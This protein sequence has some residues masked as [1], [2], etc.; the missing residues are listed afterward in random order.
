[1]LYG[2][3][4]Q[5]YYDIICFRVLMTYH[6]ELNLGITWSICSLQSMMLPRHNYRNFVS[7][8]I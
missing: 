7:D 8:K 5:K 4:P 6:A 1:M 2:E 3:L